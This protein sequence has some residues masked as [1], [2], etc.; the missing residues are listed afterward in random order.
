MRH[1]FGSDRGVLVRLKG[2]ATT[3]D[4]L[5]QMAFRAG[6]QQSVRAFDYG[7]ERG[8]A[9]WATMVDVTPWGGTFR[10]VFFA[11]AG[12]A[13]A[14]DDF[15]DPEAADRGRCRPVHLQQPASLGPHPLRP[16]PAVR[17]GPP[18]NSRFDVIIQAVR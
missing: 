9:F 5:P 4:P 11:D 12:W 2:G 18:G 6:G 3:N 10:P 1:L 7:T 17:A 8:Q 15:D 16:E 14:L 13:G